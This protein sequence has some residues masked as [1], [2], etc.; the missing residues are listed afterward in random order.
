MTALRLIRASKEFE[1]G[2]LGTPI[3]SSLPKSSAAKLEEIQEALGHKNINNTRVY[4]R[5]TQEEVDA[6]R[7]NAFAAAVGGD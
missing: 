1:I 6:A 2:N 5:T 7:S 4:L 3:S